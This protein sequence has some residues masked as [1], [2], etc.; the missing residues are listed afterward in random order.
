MDHKDFQEL[1]KRLGLKATAKRVAVLSVLAVTKSYASPEEVWNNLKSRLKTI[2]LPTVYRILEELSEKG[3]ITRIIHP[4]RQL[5]YYYCGNSAHHHHFICVSCRRVEDIDFCASKEIESEVSQRLNGRVI[6]HILQIDGLC[7]I[8]S[9]RK[10][11]K[12]A[13][14]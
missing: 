3:V 7:G 5:Y 8:C 11:T 2:G 13:Y 10:G 14:K 4:S 1:L 6:S 9:R 12:H